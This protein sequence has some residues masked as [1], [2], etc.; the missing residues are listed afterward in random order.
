MPNYPTNTE[1]NISMITNRALIVLENNLTFANTV[2]KQYSDAFGV[3][4]AKIGATLS[5]RKPAQYGLRSGPTM[6]PGAFAETYVNLVVNQ[7]QG[8]DLN[9]T[10]SELQLNIDEFEDRVL[11]PAIATLA[12]KIDYDGLALAAQVPNVVGVPGTTPNTLLTY[13]MAGVALDNN[14]APMDDQRYFCLNPIAQAVIVDALKGLFHSGDELEAQYIKGRM[15]VAAG[16][17]WHMDQNVSVQTVGAL[18]GTPLV[19]AGSQT[20]S[21]ITIKGA[22]PSITGWLKAGDVVS[23]DGSYGVNRQ[24]KAAWSTLR[25][26]TLTADVTSAADGTATLPISPAIVVTGPTQNCSASPTNNGTVYIYGLSTASTPAESTIA[27]VNSPQ[28]LMYHKD[29]FTVACVDMFVPRNVEM[30]ARAADKQVGFSIRII[31]NYDIY[32]DGLPCRL[33]VLYGWSAIRPEM[34][35]RIAA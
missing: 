21:S 13:L 28:N 25:Q 22:T 15:G 7:Q 30:G 16:G 20:G 14:S 4:G 6:V 32:G 24:S 29:A 23:F 1:L 12:N 11:K 18:G 9:F 31:R 5:L 34:A 2:N 10:T 35:C 8:V 26:F 17:T 19:S 3:D 33:D 27:G